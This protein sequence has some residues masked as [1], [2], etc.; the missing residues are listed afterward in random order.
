MVAHYYRPPSILECQQCIYVTSK[1]QTTSGSGSLLIFAG[2]RSKPQLSVPS[3][4]SSP[5]ICCS[6]VPSSRFT[7]MKREGGVKRQNA[8][9]LV[10]RF[11]GKPC[12]LL[13]KSNQGPKWRYL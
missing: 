4:R 8:P 10:R 11:S 2:F 3:P 12:D 9:D 6:V 7:Q 13:H 1:T 5:P